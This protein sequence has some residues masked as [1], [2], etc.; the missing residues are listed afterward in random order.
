MVL[1]ETDG[2]EAVLTI[3]DVVDFLFCCMV[4]EVDR[5]KKEAIERDKLEKKLKAI[6]K[7]K[8]KK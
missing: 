2:S 3:G 6:E 4:I 7:K 8:G 1:I 5:M